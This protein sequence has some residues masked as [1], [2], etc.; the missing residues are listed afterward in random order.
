[1]NFEI[2]DFV[3]YYRGSK[4]TQNQKSF[5][6]DFSSAIDENKM[7]SIF[8]F[9]Q[10]LDKDFLTL[11]TI[12]S[13]SLQKQK[14][15]LILKKNVE[16]VFQTL[17]LFNRITKISLKYKNEKRLKIIPFVNKKFLCVNSKALENSNFC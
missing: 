12:F 13:I 7:N 16:N 15:F 5:I 3:I 17:N 14:K 9:P 8:E 1:M 10:T 2:N 6:E 4:L 11:S